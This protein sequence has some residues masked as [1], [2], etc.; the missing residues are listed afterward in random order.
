MSGLLFIDDEEG[1]RRSIL[2]ALKNEP[3]KTYAAE[4]GE[5]GIEYIAGSGAKYGYRW[6]YL[7]FTLL[8]A[9]LDLKA[10]WTFADIANG[11]MAIPNLVA[12]LGLSGGMAAMTK[13][14]MDE[15]SQ[16]LHQPFK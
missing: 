15:K 10:V 6:V 4:N 7:L 9:S 2:R 13:K 1:V 11:L 5:K 12:L 3:Y 8:G 16:G 14:Y